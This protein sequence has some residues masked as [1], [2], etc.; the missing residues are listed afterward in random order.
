MEKSREFINEENAND[1]VRDENSADKEDD[2][3]LPA[4]MLR[5]AR[6]KLNREEETNAT[7][8]GRSPVR[9]SR[10]RQEARLS[11]ADLVHD[12]L[13]SSAWSSLRD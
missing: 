12:C 6:E 10:E 11:S 4:W 3:E 9:N 13:F 7:G 5:A 8:P 2:R 1:T